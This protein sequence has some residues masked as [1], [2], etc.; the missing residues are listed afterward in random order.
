M[1]TILLCVPPAGGGAATFLPCQQWALPTATV[2]PLELPGRGTRQA[3]PLAT[4]LLDLAER[5][6]RDIDADVAGEA[7][8]ALLGH[9]MG[10]LVAWEMAQLL[11]GKIVVRHLFALASPAPHAAVVAEGGTGLSALDDDRLLD[12]LQTHPGIPDGVRR[13]RELLAVGLPQI[14]ADFRACETYQ[15][16]SGRAPLDCPITVVTGRYDPT[17]TVADAQ[18]WRACTTGAFQHKQLPA[19]HDLITEAGPFVTRCINEAFQSGS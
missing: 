7:P 1:K 2:V 3:E 10:A 12:A 15:P 6:V 14:R 17:V 4:S 5:L 9:S 18:E 11:A 8:L 16:P 13:N 19:A